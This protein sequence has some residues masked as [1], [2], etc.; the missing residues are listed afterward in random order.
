MNS[1]V[2]YWG[3]PNGATIRNSLVSGSAHQGVAVVADP[4]NDRPSH[5][6]RV[7]D[8][9]L[10]DN[11]I[12][13]FFVDDRSDAIAHG[14]I[15][16]GV[17]MNIRFHGSP[18]VTLVAALLRDSAGGL[19]IKDA[20]NVSATLSAFTGHDR[21]GTL[22]YDDATARFSH[23]AFESNGLDFP[24]S[25]YSVFANT[26]A[27]I[28][29]S[30]CALGR[31]GDS[32]LY[33]NARNVAAAPDNYWGDPSGPALLSGGG[34]SG[35]IL[36]WNTANGSNVA[37]EPFLSAPPLAARVER[38]FP[39]TADATTVWEPDLDLALSLTAAPGVAAVSA[40]LVA[41]LRLHA[42]GTLTAPAPPA[43][44]FADGVVAIWVE[45][46][47]LS[48]ASA[49][50]LR[51]RTAGSGAVAVLSRLDADGRWHPLATTWDAA[52]GHIVYMPTEVRMLQGV[53]A[54]GD[55]TPTEG[56][57]SARECLQSFLAG[58]PCAEPMN[59]KLQAAIGRK[60]R[61]AIGKLEKAAV[62]TGAKR[63][64]LARRVR[65]RVQA[66]TALAARF[67]NARKGPI[68]T[69]CRDAISI[70]L[71][72]VLQRIDEGAL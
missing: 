71:Q 41:A 33:N 30:H 51:F 59:S 67:V 39:L 23:S 36:G 14:N 8:T 28:A 40:G 24:G 7:L 52:A 25:D 68:S 43:G 69:G 1:G 17:S 38:S 50:S 56:C 54:L 32:A 42:S 64:A 12:A 22:V 20:A 70:A 44:T 57:A 29:L 26:G 65:K 11:V 4:D 35:A 6:I 34:G 2:T 49:G 13:N 45:Y 5:A 63:A 53:F 9:T 19:E 47:L 16:S 58:P 55:G 21:Y 18:S 66:I 10:K 31:A 37:H 3:C 72:P 46:D 27:E 48:R 60:A 61:R 62:A 15:L